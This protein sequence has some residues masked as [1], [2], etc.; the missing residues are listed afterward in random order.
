MGG[1]SLGCL[2]TGRELGGFLG[3]PRAGPELWAPCSLP[4]GQAAQEG[5]PSLGLWLVP[6]S[7]DT[8]RSSI[9]PGR[10][11]GSLPS[12][13]NPR[14]PQQ[15]PGCPRTEPHQ[16]PPSVPGHTTPS[17]PRP[18]APGELLSARSPLATSAQAEPGAAQPPAYLLPYVQLSRDGTNAENMALRRSRH[19][20]GWECRG[21]SLPSASPATAPE[22]PRWSL[23]G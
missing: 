17:L 22:V 9:T 20:G 1:R 16:C 11:P 12:S 5:R 15:P 19:A 7:R 4:R 13:A 10:V 8:G 21:S 18:S 3:S 2:G 14:G 6:C 23:G